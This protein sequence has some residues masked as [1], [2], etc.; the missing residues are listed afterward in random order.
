MYAHNSA[1][2]PSRSTMMRTVL[3]LAIFAT[4]TFASSVPDTC[5]VGVECLNY[6]NS[7]YL[8]TQVSRLENQLL[9]TAL[10]TAARGEEAMEEIVVFAQL[11]HKHNLHLIS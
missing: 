3:F 9:K 11:F 2:R 6:S 5:E 1:H 10:A 4:T 7:P 8:Q